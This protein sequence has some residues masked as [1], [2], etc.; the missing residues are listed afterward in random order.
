[1][2][3]DNTTQAPDTR[4]A[5]TWLTYLL[6]GLLIA[7]VVLFA[8]VVGRG[9]LR[10]APARVLARVFDTY[11]GATTY[12]A[13]G[14]VVVEG[15]VGGSHVEQRMPSSLSYEAPNRVASSQGEGTS[16]TRT[17]C[18]GE[19]V[20]IELPAFGRV[21]K[22]PAPGSLAGFRNLGPG[23]GN[24][25]SQTIAAGDKLPDVTAII[26]GSLTADDIASVTGGV[27]HSDAWLASLEHPE[28]TRALT[29]ELGAGLPV[30]LWIDSADYTIRQMAVR[31][32]GADLLAMDSDAGPAADNEQARAML[33]DAS[34]GIIVRCD[35]V[36][37][38]RP[39][40]DGTF[41]YMPPAELRLVEADGPD[42]LSDALRRD[43]AEDARA[44]V[45]PARAN[46]LVGRTLPGITARDLNGKAFDVAKIKG[47]PF[48]LDFW[49]SWHPNASMKLEAFHKLRRALGEK[50]V[51]V[52][53]VSVDP[54]AQRVKS[55]LKEV[56]V[57]FTVVWLDPASAA[58][59]QLDHDYGII[60]MPHTL[61]VDA[62]LTVVHAV[63]GMESQQQMLKRL[64]GM[65]V[66][67]SVT[68]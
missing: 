51:P 11:H 54:S 61:Y 48:I 62:D 6:L 37:I 10:S 25:A 41:D 64:S 58:A 20:Y 34:L 33:E 63:D 2:D 56:P 28:G 32:T 30:A 14:T 3:D 12:H 24:A 59:R 52:V 66:D 38:N 9:Y 43:Y 67:T 5:P 4:A 15:E 27:D 40:P 29:I 1:M 60:R 13:I 7:V 65:G 39:V 45:P 31:L 55:F 18:D 49:A 23:M 36:A 47:R 26:D 19:T 53:A 17:V 44:G 22:A 46:A 50:A 42:R 8:A 68:R 16:A 57:S 21:L 35:T